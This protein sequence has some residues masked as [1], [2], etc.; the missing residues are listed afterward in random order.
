MTAA[1]FQASFPEFADVEV[2][3]I[4][5]YIAAADGHFNVARWGDFYVEGFGNF[6]AHFVWTE[7]KS[8]NSG[9]AGDQLEKQVGQVRVTRSAAVLEKQVADPF[10]RSKYGQRYRDLQ[11][12][13]VTGLV[14]V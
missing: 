8:G 10:L 14:V 12:D 3:I 13:I 1:E 11:T 2:P 4:E 5:R 9:D 6:V 7:T